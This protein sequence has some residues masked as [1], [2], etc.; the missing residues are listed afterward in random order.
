M[1][2]YG[3]R[4]TAY[5]VDETQLRELQ[6]IERECREETGNAPEPYS[7]PN[8]IG[9]MPDPFRHIVDK[10]IERMMRVRCVGDCR[11][12]AFEKGCEYELLEVTGDGLCRV[13]SDAIEGWALLPPQDFEFLGCYVLAE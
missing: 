6:Q 12:T 7:P 9:S 8:S 2:T 13:Y 3:I 10:H 5:E 11:G 4:G 1:A